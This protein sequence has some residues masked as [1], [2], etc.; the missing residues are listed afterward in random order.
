M[1]QLNYLHPSRWRHQDF[2]PFLLFHYF[3]TQT[4]TWSQSNLKFKVSGKPPIPLATNM[5]SALLDQEQFAFLEINFGKMNQSLYTKTCFKHA[6]PHPSHLYL[7]TTLLKKTLLPLKIIFCA[8]AVFPLR[9]PPGGKNNLRSRISSSKTS[10][11]RMRGH[12]LWRQLSSS[13]FLWCWFYQSSV[14]WD[15]LTEADIWKSGI[16]TKINS[17]GP[18]FTLHSLLI[19][20][21]SSRLH[22]FNHCVKKSSKI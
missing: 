13:L 8:L 1:V 9:L 20:K 17:N 19:H 15:M 10:D 12:L 4:S 16:N 11:W 7:K 2:M 3:A 21:N 5:A 22:V 6:T 14:P 18:N